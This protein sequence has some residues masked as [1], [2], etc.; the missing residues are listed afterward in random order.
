MKLLAGV[1]FE[2]L[3]EYSLQCHVV[4][5]WPEC[6][7]LLTEYYVL[8]NGS[9]D[10][11]ESRDLLVDLCAVMVY[12]D[13]LVRGL[14]SCLQLLLDGLELHLLDS[15]PFHITQHNLPANHKLLP[16]ETIKVELHLPDYL[17]S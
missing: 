10:A 14:V 12:G 2:E 15:L 8:E 4:S 17:W 5:E 3:I 1:C 9:R 11:E 6:F 13:K 16:T 7:V